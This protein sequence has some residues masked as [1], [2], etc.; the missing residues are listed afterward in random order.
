[1]YAIMMNQRVQVSYCPCSCCLFQFS[2]HAGEHLVLL[3]LVR[4]LFCPISSLICWTA[5]VFCAVAS[6]LIEQCYG[7]R[8]MT[9]SVF[10]VAPYALHNSV[11]Q[12]AGYYPGKWRMTGD[13]LRL[14]AW[15][16]VCFHVS[17]WMN[18]RFCLTVGHC[19]SVTM[20]LRS[21][22]AWIFFFLFPMYVNVFL[23]VSTWYLIRSQHRSAVPESH[24]PDWLCAAWCGLCQK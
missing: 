3:S 8:I 21:P 23:F 6:A 20:T 5:C 22:L 17:V 13:P 12:R 10:T 14:A 15:H 16:C 2:Q 9:T 7:Y 18:K 1:M 11:C 19:F 4:L 24:L